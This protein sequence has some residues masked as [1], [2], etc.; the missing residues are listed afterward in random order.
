MGSLRRANGEQNPRTR[1]ITRLALEEEL[2]S[3]V[4]ISAQRARVKKGW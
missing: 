1:V 2:A 3:E 4:N